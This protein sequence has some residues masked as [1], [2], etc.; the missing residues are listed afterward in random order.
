MEHNAYRD[1]IYTKEKFIRIRKLF[2]D[3]I[4]QAKAKL[5]KRVCSKDLTELLFVQPYCTVKQLVDADI[6]KRQT[7]A[8]YLKDLEKTGILTGKKIGRENRPET[9]QQRPDIL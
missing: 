4:E 8:E 7:A 2:N 3:A 6:A 9:M 1:N 5:P